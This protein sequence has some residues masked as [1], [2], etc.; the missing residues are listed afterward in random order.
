MSQSPSQSQRRYIP[1]SAC[2]SGNDLPPE[3]ACLASTKRV[4]PPSSLLQT[5]PSAASTALIQE[6]ICVFKVPFNTRP[7]LDDFKK[8]M[9]NIPEFNVEWQRNVAWQRKDADT[10]PDSVVDARVAAGGFGALS[11]AS[12]YHVPL[13]RSVDGKMYDACLPLFC[14]M[15]SRYKLP[16]LEVLPDRLCFRPRGDLLGGE[17][18][19]RDLSAGL[20]P[21]DL[22]F[23]SFVNLNEVGDQHLTVQKGSH[24]FHSDPRGGSFTPI[25]DK[26][27]K[28]S[29]R[30]KCTTVVV[31]PGYACVFFE[32]ILHE[33]KSGVVGTD[34]YRKFVG[35]R[36][37]SRTDAW[38][39]ANAIGRAEQAALA[40]KGGKIAP[41]FPKLYTANHQS[42]LR[43]YTERFGPHAALWLPSGKVHSAPP[44]LGAI[45]RKYRAYTPA[46]AIIYTPQRLGSW[47]A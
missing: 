16:N 4:L 22:C 8:Y 45:R 14:E 35:F 17:S 18:V 43:R 5:K 44:S 1:T 40:H 46:E 13:A 21:S 39:P 26:M 2:I 30:N 36:L 38:F 23:G 34:V 33:V 47:P 27:Q 31:P 41:M 9:L 42:K 37:T 15:G 20:S 29:F 19:H 12:A 10:D 28:A 25:T 32:N 7:M 24:L 3:S 11:F 6:G